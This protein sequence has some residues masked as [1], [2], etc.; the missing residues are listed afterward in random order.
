[1]KAYQMIYTACGKDRSGAF[2]VW[3]KSVNVTKEE[4]DEIIKLMSYKRP[5]NAPY[6]PTEEELK[7][8]FP[9]QYAYIL[10]SSGRRCVVKSSYIGKV[11]SDLD[12]RNGNFIIH[13]Y[14]FDEIEN[15]NPFFLDKVTSFR[16]SLEYREWHDNPPPASLSTE[17]LSAHSVI[18]ETTLHQYTEGEVTGKTSS[19]LQACLNC[20]TTNKAVVFNATEREQLDWY[21]VIGTLLPYPCLVK[22]TYSTQY[23]PQFEYSVI[24]FTPATVRIRNLFSSARS[25]FNYQDEQSL[26]NYAFNFMENICPQVPTGRYVADIIQVAASCGLSEVIKQVETVGKVMEVSGCDIDTALG[27][28]YL[29]QKKIG[30]FLDASEFQR[31]LNVGRKYCL[32]SEQD[33]AAGLY[34]DVLSTG[35]WGKGS[36]V[37]DLIAFVYQNSNQSV[38]ETIIDDYF[39][40]LGLYE[41]DLSASPETIYEQVKTSAPFP[42]GDFVHYCVCS[43]KWERYIA[44]S[45]APNKLYLVFNSVI[46]ALSYNFG[47][48]ENERGYNILVKIISKSILCRATDE[49]NMYLKCVKRIGNSS[50]D[51]LIEVAMKRYLTTPLLDEA[52]LD[53]ALSVCCAVP[54]EEEGIKLVRIIIMNN[55]HSPFLIPLYIRYQDKYP[56]I[57]SAVEREFRDNMQ[58]T[59]MLSRKDVYRFDMEKDV[60]YEMLRN[61]V[62]KCYRTGYDSGVFLKQVQNY[63]AQKEGKKRISET[64]HV[65]ALIKDLPDSYA[66]MPAILET[67]LGIVVHQPMQYLLEIDVT[68]IKGIIDIAKRL[69]H[70]GRKMPDQYPVLITLWLIRGCLGEENLQQ[71][72]STKTIYS[73]LDKRRFEIFATSYLAE[74]VQTYH[75]CRKRKDC[76]KNALIEAMFLPILSNMTAQQY[77]TQAIDTCLD[78][79]YYRIMADLMAYAFNMSGREGDRVRKY[80]VD[81]V[82]N[83]RRSEY[84]KLF[85]KVPQFMSTEESEPVI[86]FTEKYLSDHMSALEKLFYRKK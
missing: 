5:L 79:D 12:T 20:L 31:A 34:R 22:L 16:S 71:A 32:V 83:M 14:I 24:G 54:H 81:Y 37:K 56:V 11:Y 7:K 42:W 55:I 29:L 40:D 78:K 50:V 72:I 23:S 75:S 4:C 27:V 77:L 70:M 21:K 86:R 64:M 25:S 38:R 67:L 1:M 45:D 58:F 47:K 85:R 3:S 76:D 63:L 82:D 66:D 33:V 19:L 41:V 18:S 9:S 43:V 60:S 28:Y 80:V 30:W 17:E 52:S 13:A 8:F 53:F 6:E 46:D 61:H 57:F 49:I 44:C 15:F 36:L 2:S 10:L 39:D 51:W 84:R 26:G 74:L 48:T 65:Y 73:F 68:Y 62:E 35:K 69:Q 59:D